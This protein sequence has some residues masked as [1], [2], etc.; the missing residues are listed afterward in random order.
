MILSNLILGSTLAVPSNVSTLDFTRCLDYRRRSGKG[1]RQRP[2]RWRRIVKRRVVRGASGMRVAGAHAIRPAPLGCHTLPPTLHFDQKPSPA[3]RPAAVRL[4]AFLRPRSIASW[5]EVPASQSPS[6][7]R[8]RAPA[9]VR[10]RLGGSQD[11][12]RSPDARGVESARTRQAP[13]VT[14]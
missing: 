14:G 13:A 12:G 4:V 3:L 6:P 9:S 8:P 7:E 11:F 1:P 2:H 10:L 5:Y